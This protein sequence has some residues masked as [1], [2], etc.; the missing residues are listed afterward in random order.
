CNLFMQPAQR[1]QRYIQLSVDKLFNRQWY[2]HK[3]FRSYT[4]KLHNTCT[5]FN[6]IL[7]T[8]RY[9]QRGERYNGIRYSNC[10]PHDCCWNHFT[11]YTDFSAGWTGRNINSYWR[12]GWSWNVYLPVAV[13]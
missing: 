12:I 5:Y 9:E 1:R 3:Y 7:Q 11:R 2:L 4:N 13:F 10:I 6:N 8:Y